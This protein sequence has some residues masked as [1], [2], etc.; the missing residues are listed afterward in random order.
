[1]VDLS[2]QPAWVN[3]KER[4]REAFH[5][6]AQVMAELKRTR[7]RPAAGGAKLLYCIYKDACHKQD[8]ALLG[9]RRTVTEFRA[10][11]ERLY[12]L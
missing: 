8:E 5:F 2:V 4:V 12:A 7:Q 3:P 6:Q 1:M 10:N 9:H 11:M